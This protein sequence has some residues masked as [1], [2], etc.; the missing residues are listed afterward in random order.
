DLDNGREKRVAS[1]ANVEQAAGFAM[2]EIRPSEAWDSATFGS[3][4]PVVAHRAAPRFRDRLLLVSESG[5]IT[6]A[7][8]TITRDGDY[9]TANVQSQWSPG[10]RTLF[11]FTVRPGHRYEHNACLAV[12]TQANGYR[13][14]FCDDNHLGLF[15]HL[16]WAPDGRRAL[17]NNLLLVNRN[18]SSTGRQ[19]KGG[20]TAFAISWEPS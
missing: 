4:V 17:L 14:R 6:T 16:R 3:W 13:F 20:N 15:Y 19:L 9:D 5:R 1:V 11:E 10:G 2:Q 18:G 12:W 7:G 8:P